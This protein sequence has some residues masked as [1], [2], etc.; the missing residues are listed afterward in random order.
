MVTG[1]VRW[2][3]RRLMA[4]VGHFNR[5]LFAGKHEHSCLVSAGESDTVTALAVQ[6]L[7]DSLRYRVYPASGIMST[8]EL[9][10]SLLTSLTAN[11]GR[12]LIDLA[13]PVC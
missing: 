8:T 1:L 10:L 3:I 12:R 6:G 4:T 11:D 9:F 13:I 2:S 7:R 5:L